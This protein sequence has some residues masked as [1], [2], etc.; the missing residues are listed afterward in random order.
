[1]RAAGRWGADQQCCL[2]TWALVHELMTNPLTIQTSPFPTTVLQ[3]A[4]SSTDAPLP[5]LQHK[6]N[7]TTAEALTDTADKLLADA[8]LLQRV[9]QVHNPH[10]R[11]GTA[12]ALLSPSTGLLNWAKVSSEHH[13][14]LGG[15]KP[16][17]AQYV[18]G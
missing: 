15:C 10:V 2:A 11:T 1:M 7:R 6:D 12:G 16:A 5:G 9:R 8:S 17:A 18:E 14:P 13:R 4:A 3:V